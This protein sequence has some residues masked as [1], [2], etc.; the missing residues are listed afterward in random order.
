MPHAH[1]RPHDALLKSL[2][3]NVRRLRREKGYTQEKLAELIDVH[4]RMIQK[5]EYGQTN[6]LATTAIRLQAIL[7]CDWADLLPKLDP[8]KHRTKE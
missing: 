2:G 7:G 6:V 8:A 1:H 4:P 3:A 5:L